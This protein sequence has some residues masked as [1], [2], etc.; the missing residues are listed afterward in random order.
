MNKIQKHMPRLHVPSIIFHGF[1]NV[2]SFKSLQKT[3]SIMQKNPVSFETEIIFTYRNHS[4]SRFNQILTCNGAIR[5]T[6]IGHTSFSVSAREGYAFSEIS[7]DFHQPSALYRFITN[8]SLLHRLFSVSIN[9]TKSGCFCQTNFSN[10]P[11][12]NV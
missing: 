8:A 5:K 10:V 12:I 7:A 6:L 4:K 11:D 1:C 3:S 9:Y 2:N